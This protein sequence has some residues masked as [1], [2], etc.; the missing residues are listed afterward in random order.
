MGRLVQELVC[1]VLITWR[2]QND[3]SIFSGHA[4]NKDTQQFTN[5]YV[6][7]SLFA[8]LYLLVCVFV[9]VMSGGTFEKVDLLLPVV[10]RGRQCKSCI[11]VI[12]NVVEAHGDISRVVI[13]QNAVVKPPVLASLVED[14]TQL[15]IQL[16]KRML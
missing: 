5:C 3:L 11:H 1:V 9:C 10:S 16:I 2:Y 4:S 13:I 14:F 7:H 6:I 15:D 12:R 8:P